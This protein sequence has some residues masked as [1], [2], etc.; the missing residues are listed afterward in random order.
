MMR[1]MN[2]QLKLTLD[3]ARK[4]YFRDHCLDC[5]CKK[6]LT[7]FRM[8][9]WVLVDILGI[10]KP[11]FSTGVITF[12]SSQV[13]LHCW[14]RHLAFQ[15]TCLAKQQY[16]LGIRSYHLVIKSFTALILLTACSFTVPRHYRRT[17]PF[18]LLGG[19][20]IPFWLLISFLAGFYSMYCRGSRTFA[21][22][23]RS[24]RQPHKF[25]PV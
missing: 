20:K 24:S 8:S 12:L 14:L 5:I 25:L 2:R 10:S 11:A 21:N 4:S 15:M 7:I 13:T 17:I 23:F 18:L 3:A 9:L 1:H 6:T 16:C 22:D 19:L